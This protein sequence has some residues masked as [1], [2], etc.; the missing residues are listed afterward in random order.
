[1]GTTVN[2][3]TCFDLS[4]I[5]T[6]PDNLPEGF[7][8]TIY[9]SHSGASASIVGTEQDKHFSL[10][11]NR[12]NSTSKQSWP[13][14]MFRSSTNDKDGENLFPEG[15]YTFIWT[16]KQD[17]VNSD[18][19]TISTTGHNI[20]HWHPEL[21]TYNEMN[22]GFNKKAVANMSTSEKEGWYTSMG[23]ASR[24][25]GESMTLSDASTYDNAGGDT[26]NYRNI[27]FSG[28]AAFQAMP[29]LTAVKADDD[30]AATKTYSYEGYTLL[31]NVKLYYKA[32]VNVTFVDPKGYG[33][34]LP[35]VTKVKPSVS[36]TLP[37]LTTDRANTR[38]MGWSLEED[39]DVISGSFIP[40]GDT[41]LYA[42]WS[43][44]E[45]HPEYGKTIFNI[46]FENSKDFSNTAL[47]KHGYVNADD[48]KA[49][50][51]YMNSGGFAGGS[52]AIYG[53]N[54]DGVIVWKNGEKV[55]TEGVTD[56][57]VVNKFLGANGATSTNPQFVP[58]TPYD[59][60]TSN[61]DV[62][63]P[64]GYF[65]LST[66]TAYHKDASYS[67]TISNTTSYQFRHYTY[68]WKDKENSD[69]TVY[70]HDSLLT[71]KS[72]LNEKFGDNIWKTKIDANYQKDK[73]FNVSSITITEKIDGVNTN[74]TY[75]DI[76][77]TG[78][79]FRFLVYFSYSNRT[80]NAVKDLFKVDDLVLYW[81]PYTAN[82][83]IDMV[84]DNGLTLEG[85]TDYDTMNIVDLSAILDD[86]DNKV[87]NGRIFK[88]LSKTQGGEV[89]TEDFYLTEDTTLYA[90][91]SDDYSGTIPTTS[92]E[93]SIRTDSYHGIRFKASVLTQ[94]REVAEEYGFIVTRASILDTLD[95]EYTGLNFNMP[96]KTFASGAAYNKAEGI[97][98]K[99]D[100][101]AEEI[102]FTGVFVGVPATKA[103]YTEEIV[104]RPYIKYA[105]GKYYYGAPHGRTI[106]S[107]AEAIRDAGYPDMSE[108]A[109][110]KVKDIL[111][112]CGVPNEKNA[113]LT[114]N[115]D[116]GQLYGSV[117]ADGISS[118]QNGNV[119]ISIVD[120]PLNSG[121]G[122]VL[123]VDGKDL[124]GSTSNPHNYI[125]FTNIGFK[126]GATYT[127]SYDVLAHRYDAAGM[128]ICDETVFASDILSKTGGSAN[129][130]YTDSS[131]GSSVN[132]TGTLGYT[133]Y[134]DKWVTVTKTITLSETLDTTK[135][136][137]FGIYVSPRAR[138]AIEGEVAQYARS[139][140]LDNISIVEVTE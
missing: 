37:T 6:V 123:F 93:N 81:K 14:I 118:Q 112:I 69:A 140:Y 82:L 45:N 107:V 64:K 111:E 49:T 97:D 84:E 67:H 48:E 35:D 17:T 86:N 78:S 83:T 89:L 56:Y 77:E 136:H 80:E 108:A 122:N 1:M 75:N 9:F 74:V 76:K 23:I 125:W 103:N 54:K 102:F 65:T 117:K 66:R 99:Y 104:A 73:D 26:L 119:K 44:A 139:I 110:E 16:L 124:G 43:E 101:T 79:L 30:T 51:W 34:D 59:P 95:L 120:D 57:T 87:F 19:C 22:G 20:Y 38:M 27:N 127:I 100:V 71:T 40:T 105:D 109:I 114:V 94:Q 63:A 72:I 88:G 18:N 46:D 130:W 126:P 7:P 41:T 53:E 70:K 131:T 13:R 8:A 31:D 12:K 25:F 15:E 28:Y 137:R 121:K 132:Q 52:L 11:A 115:G 91:W 85:L 62:L 5:G 61:F 90:L 21:K 39:G 138:T 4:T 2:S 96:E 58:T 135:D 33:T 50:K 10:Y 133:A 134:T 106:L 116:N 42:V 55:E 29:T 98:F 128:D 113:I 60:N 32:P 24:L 92:T 129:C 68:A 47:Y 3:A 36:V